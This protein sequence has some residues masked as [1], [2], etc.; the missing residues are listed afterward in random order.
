MTARTSAP[1]G[2]KAG[3]A[4]RRVAPRAALGDWEPRVDR[5]DPVALLEEQAASRVPELI[6]IRYGRMM[7]S[8]FAFYRGAA[9]IMAADLA[10]TPA[11]GMRVQ[12]CG[13]AHLANF[14]AF[15]SPERRQVF[16][17]SDFDET[18]AGPWEW[19]V[20]R[21]VASIAVAGRE[22][23]LGRRDRA[24]AMRAAAGRY[25]E[26]MR[27]FAAMRTL[28]VW[29]T[30]A[31]AAELAARWRAAG[32]GGARA[33]ERS[34]NRARRK[35]SLRALDRLSDVVGG[36]RRIVS[37]PP[38]VVPVE[39][40]YSGSARARVEDALER[41]LRRYRRTLSL[42]RRHLLDGYRLVDVA[43]KVVGVG[44]VGTRCWIA[45]LVGRDDRDPLFLQFKE[46]G[47]SVLE[48]AAQRAAVNGGRRVVE[49]QRLLQAAPDVLLGWCQSSG[50]DHD[51]P[52]DYYGRQ[53]WD[54]KLSPDVERMAPASFSAFGEL[55]AW[56]LA[57]G[58]AR[59]G[60][61]A[62]IAGYLGRG[63]G[64][65]APITRFGEAYAE[66]NERDHRTL[67]EAVRAGR[68]QAI[69]G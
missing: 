61:R 64:F 2:S 10:T 24:T 29:Y 57:R 8:P 12:L 54:W 41:M 38:L 51:E 22:R 56:T 15:A 60:D 28:D 16:D 43:R 17:A 26:A 44:S 36:Q 55:C 49:G 6:P 4:A 68:V 1:H 48:R 20:K 27:A 11:S 50:I 3:R 21:L 14:G 13:D 7:A 31:D 35:D 34:L 30:S 19:D 32:R 58:H 42:E 63:D 52:R 25:R 65:E 33:L 67:V 53:L 62:A 59:S 5:A 9:A 66:Q 37:H 45:L 40:L 47:S 69:S 39:E 18:L 23:G 46:A